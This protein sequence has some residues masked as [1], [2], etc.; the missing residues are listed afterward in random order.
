MQI[1]MKIFPFSFGARNKANFIIR[2]I[3]YAVIAVG[4]GILLGS[5][6]HLLLLVVALRTLGSF[7]ELYVLCGIALLVLDY[8]QVL[9]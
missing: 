1:L 3:I 5:V 2:I 4:T 8:K 9:K 7:T 6:R